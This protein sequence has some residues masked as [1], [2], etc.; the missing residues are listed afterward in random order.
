M[1][2]QLTADWTNTQTPK[3]IEVFQSATKIYGYSNKATYIQF[4]L[5]LLSLF[6]PLN[7]HPVAYSFMFLKM[8]TGK[9][10]R[11]HVDPIYT[12]KLWFNKSQKSFK[13]NKYS[14]RFSGLSSSW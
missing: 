3:K 10:I 13:C 12:K 2:K 4:Q 5:R 9:K 8:S 11:K 6:T 14:P 1:L 7:I